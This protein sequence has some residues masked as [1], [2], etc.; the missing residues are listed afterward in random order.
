MRNFLPKNLII[1]AERC[2]K[3]LYVVGGSVR[4]H[5]ANL[6]AKN[7]DWDICGPI[8]ADELCETAKLCSFTV[9]A[10]YKNTGTVKLRD[11]ENIDYEFTSFRSDRYERGTHVPVETFFTEDISLDAKRR[12]FTCNAV[13]LDI[14]NGTLVDPLGGIPDI[15]AKRIRTVVSAEKVFGEDGLR[16]MRLARQAAQLGF[17]PDEDCFYGAKTNA[18]LIDD[19]SPE[20]IWTELNAILLA[21][22]KYGVKNVEGGVEFNFTVRKAQH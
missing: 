3:P 16:L 8:S 4:D 9:D 13:Y 20:R 12:D 6:S 18:Q 1:L 11:T 10:V 15:A 17:E 5:I 21:D 22:K 2:Q 19:I 7:N 14:K